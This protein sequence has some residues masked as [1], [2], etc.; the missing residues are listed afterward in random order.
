MSHLFNNR[1]HSRSTWNLALSE[2]LIYARICYSM[3]RR[4]CYLRWF[5]FLRGRPIY[6]CQRRHRSIDFDKSINSPRVNLSLQYVKST[7]ESTSAKDSL[8]GNILIQLKVDIFILILLL[9]SAIRASTFY[10][11]LDDLLCSFCCDDT[12]RDASQIECYC[13][14]ASVAQQVKC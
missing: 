7:C 4:D 1:T 5:V 2:F 14:S 6:I 11:L 12:I 3:F 13:T 8:F 10:V 9:K